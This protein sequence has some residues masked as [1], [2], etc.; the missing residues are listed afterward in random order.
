VDWIRTPK[1]TSYGRRAE[2]A[3]FDAS[4][5]DGRGG[6]VVGGGAVKRNDIP[7]AVA[8]VFDQL[9]LPRRLPSPPHPRRRQTPGHARFNLALVQRPRHGHQRHQAVLLSRNAGRRHEVGVSA[10]LTSVPGGKTGVEIAVTRTTFRPLPRAVRR[11]RRPLIGAHSQ[12]A[13]REQLAQVDGA[14]AFE[15]RWRRDL[16]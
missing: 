12:A 16:G 2:H 10:H 6:D 3:D 14:G 11:S 4:R 13:A 9:P 15:E 7:E 5:G 8:V 1:S